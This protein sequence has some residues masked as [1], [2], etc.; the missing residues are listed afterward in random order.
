MS[1]KY[2]RYDAY[3]YGFNPTEED[4]V[5]KILSAVAI[6]GKGYHHTDGWTEEKD[7]YSDYTG[8]SYAGWIEN[9][10]KECAREITKL[11]KALEVATKAITVSANQ[12]EGIGLAFKTHGANLN[13]KF[14]TD[15]CYE[16]ARQAVEAQ[17]QIQ[18]IMESK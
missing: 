18:E 5:N 9:S 7:D 17:K 4:S 8:G 12:L 2:R 1:D 13:I 11:K 3:Y 10:A 14:M 15:N 6:A 16:N